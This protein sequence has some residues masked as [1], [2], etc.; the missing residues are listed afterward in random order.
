M[1]RRRL[2]VAGAVTFLA[3]AGTAVTV[4]AAADAA[5]NSSSHSRQQDYTGGS[6]AGDQCAKPVAQRVGGWMC[7]PSAP[8]K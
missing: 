8:T 4:S 6:T 5:G 7:P 2:A 1:T 3:A